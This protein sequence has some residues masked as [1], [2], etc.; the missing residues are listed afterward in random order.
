MATSRVFAGATTYT[1]LLFLDKTG[2]SSCRI[3]KVTNLT[4]W[5]NANLGLDKGKGLDKGLKPLVSTVGTIPAA[6]VSAAEWNFTVGQGAALF[7]RLRQMPVKLG[8]VAKR[9]FQGFKT[10]ADPVFILEE[11]ANG[12]YYSNALE[13][14]IL[15]ETKY[16]RPLY[17]SGEMKR[18]A[19]YKNSRF[20]I[21][22]YR[23]GS[24]IDWNEI[25]AKAPKT[26]SYLKSCKEILAKRENGRWA[27]SQ[28]YCYSRNQ[29]L[30]IISS[31]KILT[32]DLNPS[33]NYC[34]D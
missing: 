5:S 27:G 11:R 6:N 20:V 9:I 34:F 12:K 32:A 19:L 10:G 28:W 31:A 29:A 24:L 21:F 1:C 17:K 13:S 23:N 22:P 4:A 16:L 14:E 2:V 30:E 3:E 26:A 18:Y 33:A 8:D 15:I 25:T 7:E